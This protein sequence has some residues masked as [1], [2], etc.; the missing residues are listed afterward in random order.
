MDDHSRNVVSQGGGASG[1]RRQPHVPGAQ[2]D[3]G[4]PRISRSALDPVLRP[5]AEAAL[6]ACA[7]ALARVSLVGPGD[8][9]P[10]CAQAPNCPR[11]ERCLHLVASA[12]LT[13]RL[14]GPFRR[15]PFGH[16]EV[17]HV[18]L[19]RRPFVV[20]DGLAGLGLAERAWLANHR[21]AAFGAWPLEYGGDVI[22]VLAVFACEPLHGRRQ[23]VIERSA[24]RRR[25]TRTPAA[26]VPRVATERT[27][28]GGTHGAAARNGH[29]RARPRVRPASRSPTAAEGMIEWLVAHTHGKVSCPTA[30]RA[31]SASSP[32]RCFRMQ[33]LGVRRPARERAA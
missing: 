5:L 19:T 24:G 4:P 33:K 1:D 32:P 21:I 17:G 23:A 11:R 7:G 13:Q 8:Q 31:F 10:T 6:H 2:R 15:F 26:R 25:G 30:P 29:G 28:T 16:G 14:D 27:A 3:S 22:G 12:G 9:C 20:N 18:P